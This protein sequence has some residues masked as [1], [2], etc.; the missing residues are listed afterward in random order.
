MILHLRPLTA[1]QRDYWAAEPVAVATG[2]PGTAEVDV[3]EHPTAIRMW[4]ALAG[5]HAHGHDTGD[6]A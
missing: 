6:A 1:D 2:Q 3:C 5:R 4:A